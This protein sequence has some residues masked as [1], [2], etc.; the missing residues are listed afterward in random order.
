MKTAIIFNESGKAITRRTMGAYKIAGMMRDK[1]WHVEVLD[2]ITH[3][4][5]SQIL[6]FVKKFGK[7]DLFA[8][9]NLWMEDDFVIDKIKFL[10]QNFPNAKY[11]LGGP[12]PYQQDFG[13]DVMIFG[14]AEHALEPVLEY[15]FNNG[16]I[17]KSKIPLFAPNSLLVDANADYKA[18]EIPDYRVD[19]IDT[20]Y[21]L[22]SD[23]LTLEMT[24][25]CRFRCK[26]CSY[27]FLGVK[28]DYSRSEES[29]YNEIMNN[30]VKWGTT[31]YVIADDTFND[32]DIKIQRLANVVERLPFQPNFTAFIRLDLV[33]S[34]PQ[35][36]ELLI[37][38]R[39]WG[40]FYGVETLH[41]DAAKAIGKGMHPDKIKKGLL[42]TKA[43][44]MDKLG[45]YRGTCGMIAGLPYE[46]VD[47]WY[48]SLE[49]MSENWDCFLFWA[50]HISTDKNITTHS[51]FSIDAAKYGYKPTKDQ[52]LLK[53]AEDQGLLDIK[54]QHT[55]KLDKSIMIWEADWANI[56]QAHNFADHYNNNYFA[57]IKVPNFELLNY[58]G[59]PKIL[60]ITA[61]DAYID[62][63]YKEPELK[64]IDT[65]INKKVNYTYE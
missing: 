12:R 55:H 23:V 32:R 63:I 6:E 58:N 45:L 3:W 35:Q 64:M 61:Q 10:K 65:Y 48:N 51:D 26:Y 4:S 27:A 11:L 18:L 41:P 44:F 33:I 39:V 22:P 29:I 2:W 49:W 1:E 9:G 15:M 34:R 60:D 56:K 14:Y 46:P 5:D 47:S 28:E 36:L 21:V 59:N 40:H 54:A 37:K 53:W 16:P 52:K 7:V 43:A 20:D 17:P 31:S 30:Y 42:E 19:Y 24:R 13:A 62:Q 38:A 57:G 25:G 8:F 50:L